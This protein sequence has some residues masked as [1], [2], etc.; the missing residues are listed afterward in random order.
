MSRQTVKKS[1]SNSP[2]YI[3]TIDHIVKE[4]NVVS[5]TE[6][7]KVLLFYAKIINQMN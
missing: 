5:E 4:D 3:S 1:I 7:I 6:D 2:L